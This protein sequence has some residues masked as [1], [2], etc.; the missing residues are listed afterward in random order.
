MPDAL[1]LGIDGGG[2]RTRA[3]L[4]DASGGLLGEGLAGAGNARTRRGREEIMNAA[5]Q[6]LAAAGLD[7]TDFARTHAGFG[8][9]GTQQDVDRQRVLD[10]PHPFASLSVDTDAYAAWLGAFGGGDGAV[11]ILG[12]GS[13]GFLVRD[14]ERRYVGGWG[15]YVGDDGSGAAL[16]RFAIRRAVLA[17]D[18][19]A[20]TTP[21]A[22]RILSDFS[23]EGQRATVWAGD[24]EPGDYAAYAALAF[25]FADEGDVM[26]IAAVENCAAGAG[27]HIRRLA[28]LGAERIAMIG[29]LYQS[30][31]AWLPADERSLLVEPEA[32]GTEGALLMARRA[33]QGI[34]TGR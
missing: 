8:L 27:L 4:R 20:E 29:G 11:L 12:T 2:T 9:A 18:G 14:G 25:E 21:F 19:M 16:G 1:F 34:E 3:R 17:L 13:C 31:L 15:F 22:E 7:D 23:F 30:L 6:A 5:R 28:A 32:D 26:A 10:A 33:F 24:A